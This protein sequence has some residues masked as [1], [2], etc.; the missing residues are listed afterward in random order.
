MN[1]L[2]LAVLLIGLT[3]AESVIAGLQ[4]DLDA[5]LVA[6]SAVE[7]NHNDKAKGKHGELSRYQLK[8]SVWKQHFPG[9]SDKRHI[10]DHAKRCAK[11]H[12]CWLELKL[13]L[14]LKTQNPDPRDVYAAWNLGLDGYKKKDFSLKNLSPKRRDLIE[15]YV[16]IYQSCRTA[17]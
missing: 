8:K 3:P 15:R 17:Q 1:K 9:E 10:P 11:A 13:C 14:Y 4:Q 12:L 6:I 16:A 2:N 7:S 5:K